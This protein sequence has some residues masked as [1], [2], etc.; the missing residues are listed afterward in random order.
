MLERSP[1]AQLKDS[2]VLSGFARFL[3]A[4]AAI[5]PV[6]VVWAIVDIERHGFSFRQAA[7][8]SVGV[9]VGLMCWLLLRYARSHLTKTSFPVTEIKAVDNEVVAYV[10]TY[11]FPLVAPSSSASLVSQ[12]LIVLVL[13]FVLAASN[14]FTF[15]PLL[16]LLGYHFYEV[17]GAA[18]VTYL[19]ISKNDITDVKRIQHVGRLSRHLMLHLD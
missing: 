10:V 8:L 19:L 14:A 4:L 11:L 5:S 2:P 15:N 1:T 17:K 13:G 16:T 7:V 3:F 18:G 9:L 12:A 6:A